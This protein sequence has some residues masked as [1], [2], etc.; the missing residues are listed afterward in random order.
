MA[1]RKCVLRRVLFF[2]PF[3][4]DGQDPR[5]HTIHPCLQKKKV[6]LVIICEVVQFL[7]TV[8]RY[9]IFV[10]FVLQLFVRD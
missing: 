4:G 1:N 8:G 6:C 10:I 9:F 3:P 5:T 2:F 7:G